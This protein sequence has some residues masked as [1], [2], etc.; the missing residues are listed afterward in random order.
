MEPSL[1]FGDAPCPACGALLWFVRL[2]SRNIL[3][4]PTEHARRKGLATI[5]AEL[6][7]TDESE[8]QRDPTLLENL[9]LDSLQLVDLLMESEDETT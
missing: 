5:L 6:L 2:G 4:P 9:D 1:F 7:G 3:L 8:L